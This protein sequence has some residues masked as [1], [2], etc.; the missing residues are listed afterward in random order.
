M[1]WH[2]LVPQMCERIWKAFADAAVRACAE[3]LE[4]CGRAGGVACRS[5]G[6]TVD[7]RKHVLCHR[8]E[9]PSENSSLTLRMHYAWDQ[10]A[11]RY[12]IGWFDEFF[13]C[14]F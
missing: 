1:Q 11:D 9:I 7:G 2:C 14:P 5:R 6:A 12:V 8:I 4:A 10:A 3:A 13:D